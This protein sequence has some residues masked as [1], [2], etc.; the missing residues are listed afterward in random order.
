MVFTKIE[1]FQIF[2]F[3]RPKLGNKKNSFIVATFDE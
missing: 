1:N 2:I 3:N